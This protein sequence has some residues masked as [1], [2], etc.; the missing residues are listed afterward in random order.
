MGNSPSTSG[1]GPGA[2]GFGAK[3]LA[4]KQVFAEG[5]EVF[6]DIPVYQRPYVWTKKETENLFEDLRQAYEG[7]YPHFLGSIVVAR[8]SGKPA[9]VIDGQQRLTT[10]F[11]LLQ[12]VR[13]WAKK[14]VAKVRFLCIQRHRIDN[15]AQNFSSRRGRRA[16][17]DTTCLCLPMDQPC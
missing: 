6:Y 7:T 5:D 3:T 12:C 9:E 10:T 15:G 16:L 1:H 4:L 2:A 13:D 17:N 14:E 11:I 8:E